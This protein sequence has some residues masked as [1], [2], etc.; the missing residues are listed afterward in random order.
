MSSDAPPSY[1]FNNINYNSLFYGTNQTG[2]TSG[3]GIS[4]SYANSHYLA[5]YSGAIAT[6]LAS[7]TSFNKK[8]INT[9]TLYSFPTTGINGGNGDRLVLYQG[10]TGIYP[11]S[12]GSS[13]ASMWYN[14]PALT[15]H[16]F[17]CNGNSIFNIGAVGVGINSAPSANYRLIMNGNMMVR[18]SASYTSPFSTGVSAVIYNAGDAGGVGNTGQQLKIGDTNNTNNALLIGKNYNAGTPFAS[19]Q[20]VKQT[21]GYKILCLNPSGRY[22]GIGITNPTV[23][24]DI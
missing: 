13:S 2:G 6:S 10:G 11:Y 8:I 22:V 7:S 21:V 24:L 16:N 20:S 5:S 1:Y 17:L 23:K 19:I 4:V 3:D 14:V 15:N 12:I 9:N 18:N